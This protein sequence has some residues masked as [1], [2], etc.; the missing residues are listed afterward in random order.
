MKSIL[1][2]YIL[3]FSL[4]ANSQNTWKIELSKKPK[5]EYMGVWEQG[6]YKI[7]VDLDQM[8]SFFIRA[9]Q[10]YTNDISRCTEKDSGLVNYYRPTA[11]RYQQA[12][13]IV[14]EAKND[15][16]LRTLFMY[17]GLEDKN[18][19]KGNSMVI[20]NYIKQLVEKGSA[21]VIYKGEQ[22]FTL[23]CKSEFKEQGGILYSGYEIRTY[24]DDIKNCIFSEFTSMGW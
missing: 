20:Q 18:Q 1:F 6:D 21:V 22:I 3:T 4:T 5:S 2:L 23:Q 19:N 11:E 16:D 17:H 7:Y 10:E 14:A 13:N 12:A 24:F 15:F 8:K 9:Y